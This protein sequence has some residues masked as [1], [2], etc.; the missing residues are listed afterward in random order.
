MYAGFAGGFK[1]SPANSSYTSRELAH[2][3]HT[4]QAAVVVVHPLFVKNLL[5]AFELLGVPEDKA[6]KSMILADWNEKLNQ[7]PPAEILSINDLTGKGTLAEEAKFAGRY[8]NETA[9]LCFSSG[10][11]GLAKGVEVYPFLKP[12]INPGS[13]RWVSQTTHK[14]LVSIMCILGAV[15]PQ[16][17]PGE[18]RFH[19]VLPAYHIFAYV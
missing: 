18:D 16:T 4:S 17:T 12:P 15:F 6:R 10:T 13:N 8:A 9:L 3:I 2:Q 14:N 1:V 5:D 11:T 7:P 19:G